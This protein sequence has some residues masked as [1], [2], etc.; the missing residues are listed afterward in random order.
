MEHTM[1]IWLIE[2]EVWIF[3]IF[4]AGR[5]N[6]NRLQRHEDNDEK[7]EFWA[8]DKKK[9]TKTRAHEH[10]NN[11]PS[12]LYCTLFGIFVHTNVV[13]FLFSTSLSSWHPSELET[14]ER[15]FLQQCKLPSSLSH[16]DPILYVHIIELPHRIWQFCVSSLVHNA[17]YFFSALFYMLLL[18]ALPPAS[19][20]VWCIANETITILHLVNAFMSDA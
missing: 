20:R 7:Q 14:K 12:A 16:V 13:C 3:F 2:K 18:C 8:N 5:K 19:T 17:E 15:I 4:L 6:K 10:N 11:N 9:T 1:L